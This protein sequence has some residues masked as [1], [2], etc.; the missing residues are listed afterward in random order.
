MVEPLKTSLPSDVTLILLPFYGICSG[1]FLYVTTCIDVF[2]C[3][4]YVCFVTYLPCLVIET[5]PFKKTNGYAVLKPKCYPLYMRKT[6]G[7]VFVVTKKPVSV[8]LPT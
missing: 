4:I 5:I 1:H 8:N 3:C 6:C 7:P 2:M